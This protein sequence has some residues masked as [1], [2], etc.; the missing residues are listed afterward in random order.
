MTR[1]AIEVDHIFKTYADGT[2]AVDDVSF[3][4]PE[5][6]CFGFL[7]PNGA[8]KTTLMKMLY[9]MVRRDPR[10]ETRV[11]VFGFDPVRDELAIKHLS[12]VVPQDNN[13]DAE[14]DVSANLLIYSKFYGLPSS[15]ARFRIPE[16]LDFMELREKARAKVNDL[17]GGMKRRLVFARALLNRP[18]LLILDEPT[19]GLDPQ[20]R[21]VL[22]DKVRALKKEGVTV[23][24]TTHYMEE[25]YQ[26][27]DAII[28]MDKGRRV[29]E[30]AP[31]ELMAK[32][33]ESWVME[34]LDPETLGAFGESF[35][36]GCLS[37]GVRRE[38][39]DSRSQFFS[40]HPEVLRELAARLPSGATHLRPTNLEDLFLRA[41]GRQ[42][43]EIQ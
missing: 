8:G 37:P 23:L 25:A 3:R 36:E 22:W 32:G 33:I 19:T 31:R 20:V 12:G 17:S 39:G 26:I 2:A 9:G 10:A 41:T 7:G 40:D 42:L 21:Q 4:I 43:N 35:S 27:A 30:G 11:S 16:L 5:G 18:R 13:L 24:L 28:I 6:T 38:D 14:V 34:V 29:I 15:D 1:N